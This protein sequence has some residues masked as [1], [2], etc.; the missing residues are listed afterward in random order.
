MISN[1]NN[2]K[3]KI[4]ILVLL[5]IL[6]ILAGVIIF[7]LS[8]SKNTGKIETQ[9]NGDKSDIMY[10]VIGEVTEVLRE[11][12]NVLNSIKHKT[13]GYRMKVRVPLSEDF[14]VGDEVE[15]HS[16]NKNLSPDNKSKADLVDGDIIIVS[17]FPNMFKKADGTKIIEDGTI[18]YGSTEQLSI[19]EKSK[20]RSDEIKQLVREIIE[21]KG[22][23]GIISYYSEPTLLHSEKNIIADL[24]LSGEQAE[25][26]MTMLDNITD[27]SDDNLTNHVEYSFNGEIRLSDS[28][29]IYYFDYA[30][31]VICYDHYYAKVSFEDM[32]Y[33]SNLQKGNDIFMFDYRLIIPGNPQSIR[34]TDIT[35]LRLEDAGNEIMEPMKDFIEKFT[36][37]YLLESFTQTDNSAIAEYAAQYLIKTDSPDIIKDDTAGVY[38]IPNETYDKFIEDTFYLEQELDNYLVRQP[39]S[40]MTLYNI[41]FRPPCN[42]P[43]TISSVKTDG[44]G[45]YYVFGSNLYKKDRI[46]TLKSLAE[47]TDARTG[48]IFERTMMLDFFAIVKDCGDDE[49]HDWKLYEWIINP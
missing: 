35:D 36:K 40:Q 17:Y 14:V 46:K 4:I 28:E 32:Q 12:V 7:I 25:S 38:R 8:T 22:E 6:L 24:K 37:L 30:H 27:W 33:V 49:E 20:F 5:T 39:K 23:A 11:E 13:V 10:S 19:Y 15:V 3:N 2:K 41:Y 44:N 16:V 42:S 18:T 31:N 48:G 45:Y 47:N 43:V 29:K 1:I 21:E 34:M 26:I 9:T